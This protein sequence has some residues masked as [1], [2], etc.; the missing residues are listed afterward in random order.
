MIS[1]EVLLLLKTVSAIVGFFVFLYE[2]ENCSF[3]DYKEFCWKFD[4]DFIE[5]VDCFY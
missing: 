1:L 5:S 3:K 2:V 4:E